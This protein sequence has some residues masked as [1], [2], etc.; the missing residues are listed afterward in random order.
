MTEIAIYLEGGGNTAQEKAELRQGFDGLFQTEKSTSREKL[1]SLRFIPCGGR[2]ETYEA[3][4]N[5]L[6][7]NPQ[8]I[9]AL[10]VDSETSISKVPVNNAEDAEIRLAHLRK[11]E[12]D[13]TRQEGDGWPLKNVVPERIHLMVQCMETWIV[14]D[15]PA[16]Q[17]FY[18]QNFKPNSLPKRVNLEKEPKNEV[19]SKLED[20]TRNT[21]K[22]AYRKIKHAS[23]L[24]QRIDPEKIATR[25]PRF[26]IFRDWL[27]A[28]LT[29]DA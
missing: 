23:E 22:G 4:M 6:E 9:S 29:G 28:S 26:V 17:A 24:L 14:S 1:T 25:C 19:T 2:K 8:R 20:A 13:E 7:C 21:Q 15:V 27:R 16:M 10:L 5:A 18:K 12:G 3:F 11:K